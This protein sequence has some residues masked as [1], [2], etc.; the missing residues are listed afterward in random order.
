MLQVVM[1]E[2]GVL[3]IVVGE[4]C[5]TI[6]RCRRDCCGRGWSIT[7]CCGRDCSTTSQPIALRAVFGNTCPELLIPRGTRDR[8]W[9]PDESLYMVK[10]CPVNYSIQHG[11]V[12]P[13]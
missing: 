2:I 8:K 13:H 6:N 4:I 7:N 1:E 10:M 9:D 11:A 3:Q 12:G 5:S